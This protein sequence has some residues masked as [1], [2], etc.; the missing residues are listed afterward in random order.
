MFQPR[1]CFI[2]APGDQTTG[3]KYRLCFLTYLKYGHVTKFCPMEYEQKW[4]VQ[5]LN[6]ILKKNPLAH[7]S[8]CLLP[9]TWNV[10]VGVWA[11]FCHQESSTI[12][13]GGTAVWKELGPEWPWGTI[14]SLS[15][16]S[17]EGGDRDGLGVVWKAILLSCLRHCYLVSVKK[18]NQY[19]NNTHTFP[20]TGQNFLE[21]SLVHQDNHGAT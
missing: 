17:A 20:L 12:G 5:L 3:S 15:C 14:F 1:G 8:Y 19:S 4:A 11:T 9:K 16:L 10:Y 2:N 6:H 21:A 18:Q 13:D 7:I